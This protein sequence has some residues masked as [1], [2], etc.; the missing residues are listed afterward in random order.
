MFESDP[1]FFLCALLLEKTLETTLASSRLSVN[2]DDH[3]K[4][5]AG[6]ESEQ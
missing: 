5:R 4:T 1:I 3:R 6:D 2:G